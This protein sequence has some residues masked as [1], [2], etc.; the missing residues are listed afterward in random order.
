M[1]RSKNFSRR[2]QHRKDNKFNKAS[3][4]KKNFMPIY[5]K[6]SNSVSRW[7]I[8]LIFSSHRWRKETKSLS[9]LGKRPNER[10]KSFLSV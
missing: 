4:P 3:T 5:S 8:I 6:V 7:P 2:L 9:L 1:S 10:N